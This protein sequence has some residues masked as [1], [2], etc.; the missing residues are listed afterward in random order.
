MCPEVRKTVHV[1]KFVCGLI[2]MQCFPILF[3]QNIFSRSMHWYIRLC[4]FCLLIYWPWPTEQF[5]YRSR[6][7]DCAGQ[8]LISCICFAAVNLDCEVTSARPLGK[9]CFQISL[10]MVHQS[11]LHV[12][13]ASHKSAA[14]IGICR[15]IYSG[16]FSSDNSFLPTPNTRLRGL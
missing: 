11:L 12:Q 5:G 16:L 7:L 8:H 13:G 4:P 9:L 3:K 15:F 10:H 6:D 1:I 2:H 14:F